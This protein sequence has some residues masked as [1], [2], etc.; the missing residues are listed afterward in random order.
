M[1]IRR[2]AAH[3]FAT[4]T[5]LLAAVSVN[6]QVPNSGTNVEVS[7]PAFDDSM[8]ELLKKAVQG[9]AGKY[10]EISKHCDENLAAEKLT[11]LSKVIDPNSEQSKTAKLFLEGTGNPQ[12]LK[13]R[14]CAGCH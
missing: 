8:L 11:L 14:S 5:L 9:Q 13:N 12:I 7:E 10:D 4:S 3:C 2:N 1:T 6:A